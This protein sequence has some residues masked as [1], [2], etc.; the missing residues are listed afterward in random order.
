MLPTP[1]PRRALTAVGL[2]L[3]CNLPALAATAFPHFLQCD[4]RWGNTLMG[5][6]GTGERATIC[7][8]GCAMSSL[9]MALNGL[10]V[11]LPDGSAINPVSAMRLCHQ[12][13]CQPLSW[14]RHRIPPR[15][16]LLRPAPV[17]ARPLP[18]F[19][20]KSRAFRGR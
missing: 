10:G 11:N 6:N 5:I 17:C 4:P 7:R 3:M 8:E 15:R 19:T 16:I 14:A 9:A 13:R 1:T 12:W 20:L 18:P 2:L